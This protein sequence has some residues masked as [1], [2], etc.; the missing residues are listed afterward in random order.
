MDR[1]TFAHASWIFAAAMVA[2]PALAGDSCNITPFGL[3]DVAVADGVS[4]PV[5]ADYDNDGDLDV[6]V[7]GG[8]G[9]AIALNQGDGTFATPVTYPTAEAPRHIAT[10]DF[11][12]DSYPDIVVPFLNASDFR[13]VLNNGDGTFG[14]PVSYP[15]IG[16]VVWVTVGDADD[17]GDIDIV[18]A[19]GSDDS[20]SVYLN[21]GAGTFMEFSTFNVINGP[22]SVEFADFTNDG[23]LDLAFSAAV[24]I[25]PAGGGETVFIM[26]NLG[27]ND[28]DWLGYTPY[29]FSTTFAV[30]VGSAP[31]EIAVGDLDGQNGPDLGVINALDDTVSI[32][33]NNGDGT[34]GLDIEYPLSAPSS[35]AF[36]DVD[37]DGDNDMLV[38]N[39]GMTELKLLINDGTGTFEGAQ[40]YVAGRSVRGLA[41]GDLDGDGINDV[42]LGDGDDGT[43][44]FVVNPGDG[45]LETPAST[46]A[47]G[48]R[49]LEVELMDMDA[50][51]DLDVVAR[52]GGLGATVQ[53]GITITRNNGD[54]TFGAP[55][56]SFNALATRDMVLADLDGDLDADVI[57]WQN[58]GS[59][60]QQL[61]VQFNN[62]DGTLAAG[63]VTPLVGTV[64]QDIN[65]AD[66]DGDNDPDLLYH[67]R[68]D[69]VFP[70]FTSSKYYTGFLYNDGF[71]AFSGFETFENP[72]PGWGEIYTADMNGDPH[73]D[74]V[75]GGFTNKI[76]VQL[77]NGDGTFAATVTY[78]AG[79]LSSDHE[80]VDVDSDG[81]TDVIVCN[82]LNTDISVFLNNGDGTLQ[83]DVRYPVQYDPFSLAV[84]DVDGDGDIDVIAPMNDNINTF[85]FFKVA[86]LLNQGDGTFGDALLYDAG[87]SCN[88]AAIGDLNGDG[89]NDFVVS[90]NG[91]DNISVFMNRCGGG[92]GAPCPADCA[93]DNG[94]GTF[95]N[96]TINIDDLLA[97]INAFGQAGGPCDIAP[98]NPDGTFGNGT[99]NI[100]DLLSVINAFGDCP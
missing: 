73:P 29:L 41:I 5:L 35:L 22:Y 51:G 44:Q 38:T 84:G 47:A 7:T 71:G 76:G 57:W 69:T 21:D 40:T 54:G 67:Y 59:D 26:P 52:T 92:G 53:P 6:A 39:F 66:L 12:G 94:D 60:D 81:D 99:I 45:T 42:V 97:V 87:T 55:E 96:G 33:F 15:R 11:N 89:A 48:T 30:E 78:P 14:T 2:S 46:Y 72:P 4:Q 43:I 10:A 23:L 62:G 36:S 19:N 68:I 91:D 24:D 63:I 82:R 90:N 95:G 32:A 8:S 77:N 1:R 86:L 50:D 34:F 13:V 65:V 70:E 64:V 93:P 27:F 74:I 88:H 31:F 58:V 98:A 25:A 28:G 61:V 20:L 79:Q 85:S 100:D 37:G 3:P 9:F 16:T 75:Y 80:F 17:D 83:T 18:C 56:P 49:L